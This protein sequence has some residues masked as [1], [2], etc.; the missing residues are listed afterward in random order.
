M[1]DKEQTG[2][3]ILHRGIKGSDGNLKTRTTPILGFELIMSSGV[4]LGQ[5]AEKENGFDAVKLGFSSEEKPE[6]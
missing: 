4:N 5:K 2:A 6:E 3:K 1:R